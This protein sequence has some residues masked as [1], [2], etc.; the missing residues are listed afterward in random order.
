M[1]DSLSSEPV[2]S[3]TRG[4]ENDHVFCLVVPRE[5]DDRAFGARDQNPTEVA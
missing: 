4:D 5:V 3:D 2:M 1:P